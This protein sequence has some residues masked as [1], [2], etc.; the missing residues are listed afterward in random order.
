MTMTL[1]DALAL[2][3]HA[4]PLPHLAGEALRVLRAELERLRA[5]CHDCGCLYERFGLDLTLPNDQW[6]I[7]SAGT[8]GLLCASCI[9]RRAAELPGAIAVR[10]SIEGLAAQ[11]QGQAVADYRDCCDTPA[12]CSSVRRC[13]A[14]DAAPPPSVTQDE[15]AEFNRAIQRTGPDNPMNA[16]RFRAT[17][18]E[19]MRDAER[20]QWL[21]ECAWL[22]TEAA[23]ACAIFGVDGSMLRSID[24]S[25]LDVAIDQARGTA[26][27]SNP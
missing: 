18:L 22:H 27:E 3:D 17:C 7:V 21:R 4:S 26:S 2:A 24:G 10:A 8:N 12:Y 16:C 9:C 11:Q 23:P 13:T 5:A 20:Y 1:A 14:K 6:A 15:I 19:L 25:D